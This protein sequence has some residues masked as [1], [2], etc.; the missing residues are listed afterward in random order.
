MDW[1]GVVSGVV[2][3]VMETEMIFSIGTALGSY[4]LLY[5]LNKYFVLV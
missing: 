5:H 3:Y 1:E 2:S 4:A